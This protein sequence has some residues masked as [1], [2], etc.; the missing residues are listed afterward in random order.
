V[1]PAGSA[2]PLTVAHVIHSLGSGGAEAV[3]VEL[4]QAAPSAGV[5]LVV[6]GL[7]DA[8]TAGGV[9]DRRVVSQMQDYGATVYEMHRARYDPTLAVRLAKLFRDER[10]DIVHTH[11]K[12]ADVV[13]GMAARLARLPSVSTLHVID[14]PTSRAHR[15]RVETAVFARRRMSSNVIAL[16]SAQRRWYQQYAGADAAITLLPNGVVEP[17]ATCDGVTTRAEIGVPQDA[18]FALC[19]SLM[20][21]EK[22]HFDLLEAIRQLPADLPLVVGMA[23]DGPLLE[24]VRSTVESDPYLRERTRL[25]GFRRDVADLL[26]ASD[27]VVQPSLEDALPTALISAL[28]AARPIVA[29]N[30]GGI[31]DIVTAGCGLLVESGS[32]SALSAGITRMARLFQTDDPAV[33]EMRR[34]ARERYSSHFS[35]DVW[36]Q[37]LRGVYEEAICTRRI[38]LRAWCRPAARCSVRARLPK[39]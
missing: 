27:F 29:T 19:I 5:R 21:P 24:S 33:E 9:V 12:H 36:V 37:N 30:V 39:P 13:G 31:P 14:I 25:L 34:A 38:S 8:D 17:E 10:V 18:L 26:V 28:A 4:A 11:L 1:A 3:L 2:T 20:R 32:P 15:L 6:V 35:A 7:S 16:S 23:G 22:G